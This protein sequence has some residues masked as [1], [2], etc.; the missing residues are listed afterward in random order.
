MT[1]VV[2]VIDAIVYS[3]YLYDTFVE[4]EECFRELGKRYVDNWDILT[5]ENIDDILDA[6]YIEFTNG[7]IC[8]NHPI[9]KCCSSLQSA[10]LARRFHAIRKS[11][12]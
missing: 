12:V 5:E 7:S 3:N 2:V 8:I 10:V 4:A 9:T 11:E 6:G 1:N